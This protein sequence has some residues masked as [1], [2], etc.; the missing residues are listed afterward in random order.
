L[1]SKKAAT[2]IDQREITDQIKSMIFRKSRVKYLKVRLLSVL[3]VKRLLLFRW[4]KNFTSVKA[5]GKILWIRFGSVSGF[6]TFWGFGSVS[7][8][9]G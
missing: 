3:D 5:F 9:F 2:T 8:R 1:R 4:A 6:G 7:V